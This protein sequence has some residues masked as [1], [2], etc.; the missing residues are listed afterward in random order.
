[1]TVTRSVTP[2][3]VPAP[4]ADPFKTVRDLLAQAK[5]FEAAHEWEQTITLLTRALEAVNEEE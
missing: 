2:S 5:R 4:S 1:M 3:H